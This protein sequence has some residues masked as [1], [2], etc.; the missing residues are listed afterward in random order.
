MLNM[1]TDY[2]IKKA[3]ITAIEGSLTKILKKYTVQSIISTLNMT[4]KGRNKLKFLNGY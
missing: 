4:K 3:A 1:G 2:L